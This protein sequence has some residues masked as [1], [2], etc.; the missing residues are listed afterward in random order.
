MDPNATIDASSSSSSSANTNN[1]SEQL[2]VK[3][4]RLKELKIQH[5]TLEA[6]RK[7]IGTEIDHAKK[8]IEILK[9]FEENDSSDFSE[10]FYK[11]LNP[12][13]D[14]SGELRYHLIDLKC[15]E[16]LVEWIPQEKAREEE[17]NRIEREQI[18]EVKKQYLEIAR[19]L[20]TQFLH[21]EEFEMSTEV[22]DA[23]LTEDSE[24]LEHDLNTHD[25][26]EESFRRFGEYFK[27]L[28]DVWKEHNAFCRG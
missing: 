9:F 27:I 7:R 12:Y 17:A 15:Y 24:A 6:K 23:W 18:Q 28:R 8:V 4:R 22:F 25:D 13:N 19:Y 3:K 26:H 21:H 16:K 11:Q 14:A 5:E 1:L 10:M 20:H 2:A